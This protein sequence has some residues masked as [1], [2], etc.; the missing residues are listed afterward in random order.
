M[1]HLLVTIVFSLLVLAVPQL[2][3]HSGRTNKY[4]CH[5]G[6]QPYHCHNQNKAR[7]LSDQSTEGLVTE[8]YLKIAK[9]VN[10]ILIS[11]KRTPSIVKSCDE[12]IMV[13]KLMVI[14][15]WSGTGGITNTGTDCVQ[16]RG[17]DNISQEMVSLIS[18]LPLE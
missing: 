16:Q 10:H 2:S 5:S 4:G 6:S 12:W 11:I 13:S 15:G 14:A 9:Q 3:A 1:K 18:Q 8:S 17:L 7:V